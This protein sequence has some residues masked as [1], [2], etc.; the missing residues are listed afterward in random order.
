MK[1]F[2]KILLYIFGGAI[3]LV[4]AYLVYFNSAYPKVD[5]P[6]NEKVEITPARLERGKYLVHHVVICIDCHSTHD[7]SKLDAPVIQNTLGI[8]GEEFN[9]QNAGV[10]GKLYAKNITPAAIGNWTD[11]ELMRTITCGVNKDNV[12]LFPLMPYMDYNSLTKEDLYSIVAYIRSLKPIQ[13]SVQERSLNFPLNFLV[14]TMP[15]KSYSPAPEPNMNNPVEYGKYLVT[16]A[17][18]FD[19]HTQMVKGDYVMD[20]SFAGGFEFQIPSGTVRSANITP[21]TITGIGNWTKE[22]FVSRFKAMDPDSNQIPSVGE[23]DFNSVMPWT[24][25]GGMKR[26]DLGA[27]Y[28]YLRTI[29]PIKNIVV[30]FTPIL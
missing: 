26:E 6:S 1:K 28:N 13:N 14:K 24:L 10:P 3:V 7:Y 18:C 23:K 27:M 25:Y 20:K 19:C 12:A 2:F 9:E 21:D 22:Q 16:V 29:P 15:L 8:G 30:K 17:A 11:G 5:P 4:A